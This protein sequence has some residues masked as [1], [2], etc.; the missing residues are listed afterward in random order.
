MQLLEDGV[1]AALS[2]VGLVTLLFLLRSA[3]PLPRRGG[4]LDVVALVPCRSGEGAKLEQT[5]RALSHLRG[6]LGGFRRIVILDRGM[7]EEAKQV[8]QLL[9]RAHNEVTI[10]NMTSLFYESELLHG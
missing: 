4:A 5:V 9:C 3:L 8:A 6:E 2:A 7:D 1:L 10:C